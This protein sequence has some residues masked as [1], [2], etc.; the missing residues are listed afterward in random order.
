MPLSP[1]AH[2]TVASL[3]TGLAS[4]AACGTPNESGNLAALTFG[5]RSHPALRGSP[6]AELRSSCGDVDPAAA[7]ALLLRQPYLQDVRPGEVTIGWVPAAESSAR[8]DVTL[9]DGTFVA[10]SDGAVDNAA[11]A[12]EGRRQIWAKV[13][14]LLPN[15]I[16][17]YTLAGEG[18]LTTRTGFRTAPS[19][20]NAGGV[21]FL[22]FGDS[23]GGGSDQYA[24]AA[25]M[26]EFPYELLIHTGDVAYGSGTTVQFEDNVFHVYK[27]LFRNVAFFPVA[28]NHDYD[29]M[30]AAPFASVFA[31]PGTSRGKL[32][33]GYDWG[34][35]HF[36]ALDTEADYAKQVAWLDD[37]L[38]HTN[39]PWKVLYMHRP[40]YSSGEHGSDTSL[41]ALLAPV[42]AKHK[43]QLVLAG[44]DHDYERTTPQNGTVFVVTGG[45]G[46]GTRGV[47]RSSFTAFSAAVIHFVYVEVQAATMTLHAVDGHGVEFDSAVLPV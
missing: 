39:A 28:G 24:L 44:H 5:D 10:S 7:S 22:A 21:R 6:T 41:R 18:S 33:Y 34:Q 35:V 30:N 36:A 31:L 47:G 14:G 42:L 13:N 29:T 45:G 4:L 17:C 27:E 38:G 15:T 2:L 37:D 25:H 3:V 1:L 19:A 16:Y 46:V 20:E 8:V 40:P 23:G 9:P 43:V 26:R 12:I 32:Y 11:E